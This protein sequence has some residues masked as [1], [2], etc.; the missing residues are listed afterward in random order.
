MPWSNQGGGP[1]GSGGGSGGGGGGRGPWGQGP[2]QSG[3]GGS[4]P[5][6]LEELLRR[7]Q[8]KLK[9]VLPGGGMGAPGFILIGVLAVAV[10]TY[11]VL[12][13]V[14]PDELGLVLRFG[15]YVRDAKPGLN[16]QWPYPIE[17]VLL[18]KVT[19]VNRI[20]IGMRIVED[21]RRGSTIR[22]VPEE[23]LMLTGDENIVDV[24]FTVLWIIKPSGAADYQFNIQMADG[25]VKAV[26]ESAMREIV[27]RTDSEKITTVA[28]QS[29]ETDVQSLMQK[30][31]DSYH[32]GVQVTQVQLQKVDPPAQVL[33]SLRDVQA[34]RIDLERA[35]NEAQTY[36]NRVVPEARGRAA[37]ILQSAEAYRE[38]TVAEARGQTARFLS[39]Y[40]EYKKAP[41][42]TRQRM[43][44]ETMERL[45]GSNQTTILDFGSGNNVVPFLSLD[46]FSRPQQ[47]QPKAQQPQPK[48]GG[49]R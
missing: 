16:Y 41:D 33:D 25:T 43:Y 27:G 30:I 14:Q 5:P 29:I 40:D 45:L 31:L 17:T 19:R 36:A 28:R 10:L 21:L 6:D 32:A 4:T 22:D 3:G 38:Q 11:S 47:P 26:A 24:D 35:Q 2:Q 48:A 1:W 37:Q 15:Q 49:T 7:S 13:R 20:D 42:V 39:V 18:P 23:S 46:Q 8:D 9:R 34:A 44:L 12:F